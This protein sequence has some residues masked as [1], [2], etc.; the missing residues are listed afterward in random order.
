VM[1]NSVCTTW[2]AFAHYDDG[3]EHSIW[4]SLMRDRLELLSRLL[5]DDGCIFAQVDDNEGQYLKVLMDEIFGRKNFLTTFIWRKVDSPNDNKV[6]LTPDH[7]FIFGYAKNK[8]LAKEEW[9]E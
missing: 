5:A 4:L 2:S 3:V 9:K 1:K 8:D 7:E 6:P